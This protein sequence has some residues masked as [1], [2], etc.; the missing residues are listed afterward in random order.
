MEEEYAF[1]QEA[2]SGLGIPFL[3]IQG[4]H[5]L[6]APMRYGL[7]GHTGVEADHLGLAMAFPGM[8]VIA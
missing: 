1:V 2:L 5:D 4:N 6:R 8:R 7:A 3:A